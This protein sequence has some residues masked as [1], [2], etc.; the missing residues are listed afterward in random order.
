L[1]QQ[2]SKLTG[3]AGTDFGWS[4]AISA[5]GNTALV[6]APYD[7]SGVGAAFVYSR[8]GSTWTQQ[9]KLTG[10]GGSGQSNFGWSVALSADGSRAL[11][12][13]ANDGSTATAP[14]PGAAWMFTRSGS[15]WTQ[16]AKVNPDDGA[17]GL[18]HFGYAV[19]LSANGDTALVG[20]PED[21]P[22]TMRETIL[23]GAVWVFTRSGSTWTQQGPKLAASD[24]PVSGIGYAV[25]LSADG[26]T[27]LLA[28]H[29]AGAFAGAAWVFTRSGSTWTEGQKLTG[30]GETSNNSA[31]G[32]RVALS[33]DGA[34]AA[35]AGPG[36]D[37]Q[38]GAV[39]MFGRS[40]STW[41]QQG[42]KLTPGGGSAGGEFGAGVALT[43]DG[44]TVLIGGSQ[45]GGGTGAAWTFTRAGSSWQQDQKLTETDEHGL[46]YFGGSSALDANGKTALIAGD[47]AVFVFASPAAAPAPPAAPP[48]AVAPPPTTTSSAPGGSSGSTAVGPSISG[49]APASGRSG[50]HVTVTGTRFAQVSKVTFN[51]AKAAF[52]VVSATKII[53][54]VPIGAKTGTVVVTTSA[55]TAT[56]AT[57]FKVLR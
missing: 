24:V 39:W 26:D 18:A 13:G 21:G 33:G 52:A 37:G 30:A 16:E 23:N 29:G 40:G 41:S 54:T 35:I 9:A 27:A 56:S 50:A 45:E 15:T 7:N 10:N 42:S 57:A 2:T 14:G 36:D 47:V 44:S 38:A 17:S 55:G 32:N 3:P 53:A 31:F 48:P 22:H 49:F 43:A 12:G 51:G 11:V 5:D 46:D 25:A 20:G 19:A 8:S 28:A 1:V 34:T 4:V 6:G